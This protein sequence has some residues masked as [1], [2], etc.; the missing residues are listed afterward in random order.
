[1]ALDKESQ[2]DPA[3][4]LEAIS[5]IVDDMHAD[6]TLTALSEKWY[7]GQDLTTQQ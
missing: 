3:S 5:S 4:L 6:G 2:L 1:V 7:D